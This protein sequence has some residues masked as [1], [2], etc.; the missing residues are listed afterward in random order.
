MYTAGVKPP[1]YSTYGM[2][3]EEPQELPGNRNH[4]TELDGR[5]VDG[6][7]N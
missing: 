6:N 4:V 1:T 5:A 2:I 3:H 7:G